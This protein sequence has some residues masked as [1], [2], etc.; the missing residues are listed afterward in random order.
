[1][2]KIFKIYN[3]Q[4]FPQFNCILVLI[5]SIHSTRTTQD[6]YLGPIACVSFHAFL[7][8]LTIAYENAKRKQLDTLLI[9]YGRVHML[10]SN[11]GSLLRD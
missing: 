1:M 4:R 7:I 11:S 10:K 5:I 9:S 6:K 8:Y 3:S 2:H